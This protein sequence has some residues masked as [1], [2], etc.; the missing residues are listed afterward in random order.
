M[1]EFKNRKFT[2]VVERETGNTYADFHYEK[3]EFVGC[4][5]GV[6]RDPSKRSTFVNCSLRD[7][8][9]IKCNLDEAFVEDSSIS[10][11]ATSDLFQSFGAAFKHVSISGRIGRVMFSG[12]PLS[13][14][15]WPPLREQFEQQN[16]DYYKNVDWALDI[17]KAEFLECDIRQMPI[18]LIRRDPETQMVVTRVRAMVGD[19]RAMPIGDYW[20]GMLQVFLDLQEP[21]TILFAPKRDK[22]FKEMLKGLQVLR[23]E[24]V[25]EPD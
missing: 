6:T 18:H 23:A 5:V 17:S 20:K 9:L 19:W 16:D 25:V 2:N 24:G 12:F 22:N 8:K 13:V 1:P 10:N 11:L 7:C 4:A 14:Y 3:C 15:S 21:S